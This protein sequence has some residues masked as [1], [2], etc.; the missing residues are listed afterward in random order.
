MNKKFLLLLVVIISCITTTASAQRFALKTNALYWAAATPNL[1]A[2][3]ALSEHST[4]N[5]TLQ[6]NPFTIGADN[7]IQHFLFKPEY[8]YW[9]SEKFTRL[10]IGASVFGG[11]FEVGGF[12]LPFGLFKR[13]QTNYYKGNAFGAGISVGYSFY[14]SPHFN[15]ETTLGVGIARLSYH[16]EPVGK[17]APVNY[18]NS[19]KVLPVPT[20][21]GVSFVYLF[22]S[23]R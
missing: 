5:A 1:G 14:I 18:K 16:T 7:K 19:H 9:F 12:K 4:L 8:R 10:F 20:E 13:L 2:E 6:Y 22:K 3:L 15:I 11:T 23:R 21:F 17:P